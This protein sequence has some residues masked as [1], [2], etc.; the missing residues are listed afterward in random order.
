MAGS[1]PADSPDARYRLNTPTAAYRVQPRDAWHLP[2]AG[3]HN[4]AIATRPH[5]QRIADAARAAGIDPELLHAVVKIESGYDAAAV[6]PKGARGLAQVMPA[7]AE[8]FGHDGLDA[9]ARYLRHLIDR[10]GGDLPLALAA[11]NAGPGAVERHGGMPPYAETQAY[12]PR[13]LAEYAALRAERR[14]LP[15]RW[16]QGGAWRDGGPEKSGS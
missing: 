10:F 9:G 14:R 16:Q 8:R 5:A 3:T 2:A 4:P 12:V 1:A 13:V 15:T 6:S 7:T 11:Y